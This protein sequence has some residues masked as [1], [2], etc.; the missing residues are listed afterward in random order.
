M[1]NDWI[2]LQDISMWKDTPFDT[3]YP[4]LRGIQTAFQKRNISLNERV[5]LLAR[6]ES[7]NPSLMVQQEK[8]G[9]IFVVVVGSDPYAINILRE[10]DEHLILEGELCIEH[11][12]WDPFMKIATFFKHYVVHNEYQKVV[13][14]YENETEYW[15]KEETIKNEEYMIETHRVF[16]FSEPGDVSSAFVIPTDW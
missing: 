15:I 14:S 8:S 11:L 12:N 2:E 10:N 7:F 4:D 3:M 5:R 16:H 13:F 1:S 9:K 6:V